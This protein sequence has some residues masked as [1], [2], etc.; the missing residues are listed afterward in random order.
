MC[1]LHTNYAAYSIFWCLLISI[2][3]VGVIFISLLIQSRF[4]NSPL[5]TVVESTTYPVYEI[6]YPAITI[7]NYNR[8]DWD[9]VDG[10]IAS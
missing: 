7:C 3:A 4:H 9:R 6:S 2:A 1:E 10:A 5:A 8:I